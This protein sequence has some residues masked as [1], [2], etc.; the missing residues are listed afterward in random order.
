MNGRLRRIATTSLIVAVACLVLGAS[1][2]GLGWADGAMS[3]LDWKGGRHGWWR[4][5]QLSCST[6]QPG[7]EQ[8]TVTLP[9]EASDSLDISLPASV[10]YQPGPKAE[11]V[12]SGDAELVKHVRLTSRALEFDSSFNCFI[13]GKLSVRLTGPAVANWRLSGSSRLKLSGIDQDAIEI[14]ISGSGSVAATGAARQ[15]SLRISGS[16]SGDLARLAAKRAEIRI[17][18]SGDADIAAQDEAD[19]R[20]S[21]SGS[22][23]LH[24]HPARMH[25]QISG[26]GRVSQEP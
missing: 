5:S 1:L 2:G 3:G 10:D 8:S 15:M 20:I 25:S 11:A 16:G 18:G 22:L 26:S 6:P 13:G 7:G 9:W 24:G 17:S 19:V 21:G 14:G 23:R 12:V 4:M